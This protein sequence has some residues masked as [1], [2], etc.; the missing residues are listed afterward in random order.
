M[1]TISFGFVS[2]LFLFLFS[3][4]LSRLFDSP[5]TL[6]EQNKDE[7][8]IKIFDKKQLA[9]EK[10]IEILDK[11][12]LAAVNPQCGQIGKQISQVLQTKQ[13]CKKD[14][15]C[16][17]GIHRCSFVLNNTNHSKFHDLVDLQIKECGLHQFFFCVDLPP[18]TNYCVDNE[19]VAI[20]NTETE[21]L[22][23]KFIYEHK[24]ATKNKW[25]HN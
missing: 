3:F 9:D 20:E 11:E 10:P 21:T 1:K 25:L 6:F 2:A 14:E 5:L 19:C 16:S 4:G 15:E 23:E 13:T 22:I 18:S 24:K 12:Q 7:N 8:P 17:S